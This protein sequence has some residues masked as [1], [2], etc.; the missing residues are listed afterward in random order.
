VTTISIA[1]TA[2]IESAK[3]TN[4]I[5]FCS[6]SPMSEVGNGRKAMKPR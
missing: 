3:T 6:Y 5:G 1:L 4:A 2:A